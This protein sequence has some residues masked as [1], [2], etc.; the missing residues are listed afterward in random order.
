MRAKGLKSR[1][2]RVRSVNSKHRAS[3]ACAAIACSSGPAT[4]HPDVERGGGLSNPEEAAGLWSR[5]FMTYANPTLARGP[6]LQESD[7]VPLAAVEDPTNVR[8]SFAREWENLEPSTRSRFGRTLWAMSRR[9]VLAG[10]AG[11]VVMLF[12]QVAAPIALGQIVQHVQR[13]AAD[14][15]VSIWRGLA[16]AF[17]LCA[18]QLLDAVV[19]A[20]T[21]YLLKR[22]GIMIQSALM[23]TIFHRSLRLTA[24]GRAS[25]S[26]GRLVTQ[27]SS[28]AS[29]WPEMM[30][31]FMNALMLPLYAVFVTVPL[32]VAVGPAAAFAG[33]GA[34]ATLLLPM[35]RL[36]AGIKK[37]QQL[38]TKCADDRLQLSREILT[39]MRVAKF[40]T[41]ESA[42]KKQILSLREREDK[43]LRRF[44]IL[45]AIGTAAGS[46][47]AVVGLITATSVY[48]LAHDTPMPLADTF[49]AVALF[50]LLSSQLM[51][52]SNSVTAFATLFV[53]LNRFDEF[54]EIA[55]RTQRQPDAPSPQG[56]TNGDDGSAVISVQGSFDWGLPDSSGA[57][58]NDETTKFVLRDACFDIP[59]GHLVALVGVVGAGKSSAILAMLGEMRPVEAASKCAV[60][61]SSRSRVAYCAQ[62]AFIMNS[63]VAENICFFR[64]YDAARLAHAVSAASLDSDL[65]TFPAGLTTEIG[66][67]GI[68]LS[69]GQKQRVAVA[70]ALYANADILFFDD[71]LSAVDAHVAR[72]LWNSA[73]APTADDS[74]STAPVA[75]NAPVTEHDDANPVESTGCCGEFRAEAYIEV[76]AT[77]T[78]KTRP[79]SRTT[80]VLAT[81]Q[82]ALLDD[83]SVDTI[84]VLE[85]G[86]VTQHGTYG[87][88]STSDGPFRTLLN[89]AK[90]ASS[91]P[92]DTD[93]TNLTS[94]PELAGHQQSPKVPTPGATTK[95]STSQSKANGK[96]TTQETR[97]RGAVKA[98]TLTKYMAEGRPRACTVGAILLLLA[99][100]ALGEPPC[101]SAMLC[102]MTPASLRLRIIATLCVRNFPRSHSRPHCVF[103]ALAR[104]QIGSRSGGWGVGH[105]TAETWH[106]RAIYSLPRR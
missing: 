52:V 55:T 21:M 45:Y 51:E 11:N 14:D 54:D 24:A 30:P 95:P 79:S 92:P 20:H 101:P 58:G 56:K 27:M 83:P 70:R 90:S 39:G 80:R 103:G 93:G 8:A 33:V 42:F 62:E 18:T 17:A 36:A 81:Q 69:G 25:L 73:I 9:S 106:T 40:Y 94:S 97:H 22:V 74:D 89:E 75:A 28:D 5:V 3:L 31:A 37:A 44:W 82:I 19:R 50:K 57:K 53:M 16:I 32:V 77:V 66:S 87:E 15:G 67:R 6:A 43:Q 10:Y 13:R 102:R 98:S 1:I 88:L 96:L 23:A 72:H 84:F 59:R 46:L 61:P 4:M 105:R 48:N 86:S 49:L 60:H 26:S 34:V 91:A 104:M 38:K 63:T 35:S 78:S 7:E 76:P 41:W 85:N 99:M 29:R 2:E 65:A 71:P 100:V 12:F 68:N 47:G 64:P